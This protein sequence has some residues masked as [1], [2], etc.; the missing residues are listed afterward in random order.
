MSATFDFDACVQAV[1]QVAIANGY[2]FATDWLPV[3]EFRTLTNGNDA[4]P[5]TSTITNLNAPW[6]KV[7]IA[8]GFNPANAPTGGKPE[9]LVGHADNALYEAVWAYLNSG[10][11]NPTYRGLEKFL[12]ADATLPCAA[13]VRNRF[14]KMGIAQANIFSAVQAHYAI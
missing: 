1:Q 7:A 4:Y 2:D 14:K 12:E 6:A 9:G 5:S 8:A 10:I 13:T 11:V 3:A